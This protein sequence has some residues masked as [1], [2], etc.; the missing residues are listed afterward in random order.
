MSYF[1]KGP[2]NPQWITLSSPVDIPVAPP[3]PTR[4]E[5]VAAPIQKVSYNIPESAWGSTIMLSAGRRRLP[6]RIIWMEGGTVKN[7]DGVLS[8][9]MACSLG[10]PLDVY[11]QDRI[12]KRIWADG[13]VVWSKSTGAI[14]GEIDGGGTWRFYK[15][16]ESQLQ[17][18][19]HVA[20]TGEK[21]T[22]AYRGQMY[23]MVMDVPLKPFN[24]QV[25]TFSVEVV[26]GPYVNG[27][28]MKLTDQ[29]TQ[30]ATRVSEF[31][32]ETLVFEGLN[33]FV[34]DGIVINQ[35][36]AFRDILDTLGRFYGFDYVESGGKLKFMRRVTDA[37][38][39]LDGIVTEDM[40]LR[41]GEGPVVETTRIDEEDL[42]SVVEIDYIDK[43]QQFQANTQRAR[44]PGFP[45]RVLRSNRTEKFYVPIVI[46][47]SEAMTGA[48]RALYR[49]ANQRA[50]HK[51]TLPP[52][53]IRYEPGDVLRLETR[54]KSYTVKLTEANINSDLSIECSAVTLDVNPDI[55]STGYAGEVGD[56]I[57]PRPAQDVILTDTNTKDALEILSGHTFAEIWSVT[58]DQTI[59][60]ENNLSA[61]T[62]TIE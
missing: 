37:Q 45:V 49:D 62:A 55:T 2:L 51:F 22:P 7:K 1:R 61:L 14:T 24:D 50:T 41:D 25:P 48:A 34:N 15:G 54:V 38:Y 29:I 52:S 4:I 57:D 20:D 11:D 36:I 40:L 44:R 9:T 35:S 31:R 23:L 19:R 17:D 46:S 32:K 12:V 60:A 30:L 39:N 3:A 43:T 21:L 6:S 13:R 10:Y 33:S 5:P 27:G 26:D 28:R 47:A 58:F 59:P 18:P 53:G 16:T 8:V 56:W 42:P